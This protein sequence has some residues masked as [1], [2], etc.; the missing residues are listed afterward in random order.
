MSNELHKPLKKSEKISLIKIRKW[1]SEDVSSGIYEAIPGFM[2][3]VMLLLMVW[4][5][6][7]VIT[8][9]IPLM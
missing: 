2:W 5:I 4:L 8:G 7:G 6:I 3:Y 1:L 9:D